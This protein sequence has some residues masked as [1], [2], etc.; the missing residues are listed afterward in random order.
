MPVSLHSAKTQNKQHTFSVFGH[1][2]CWQTDGHDFPCVH[3]LQFV[4]RRHNTYKI[5]IC[6]V[7]GS[8]QPP[9][10]I[11]S[12]LSSFYILYIL[13]ISMHLTLYLSCDLAE[14]PPSTL[15]LA[16]FAW[17]H[18]VS[19]PPLP[20]SHWFGLGSAL[21]NPLL[22]MLRNLVT[23]NSFQNLGRKQK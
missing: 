23:G 8:I 1:I 11:C 3:F 18:S 14:V 2:T 20:P 7:V 4:Q 13:S 21:P 5:P 12:F 17:P 9:Y 6:T 22:R 16:C 19:P 10:I 15:W